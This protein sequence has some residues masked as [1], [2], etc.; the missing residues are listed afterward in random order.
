MS[1]A[2]ERSR[3]AWEEVMRKRYAII[4]I[5]VT[6]ALISGIILLW[7]YSNPPL[8]SIGG[9]KVLVIL[10]TGFDDR[11]YG[12]VV[13]FLKQR[14]ADV[15]TASFVTGRVD[16][17]RGGYTQATI[18]FSEVNISIFDA[19][20]IPGGESPGNILEDHRNQTVLDLVKQANEKGKILA[21]ICHGPWILAKAEVVNGK[22][23]VGHADTVADLEAA[24][25]IVTT[26][27]VEREGN[28]ITA[29]FEGLQEFKRV[30]LNAI[31]EKIGS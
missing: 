20:F 29:Q 2:V 22:R 30:L 13:S 16:G 7:N 19:I 4:G 25:G 11:E 18:A 31:Y 3:E 6:V 28:I 24:G 12:E 8:P 1:R 9:T 21:A 10:T 23:V 26:K 14:G 27:L 5:T 15:Q 17:D